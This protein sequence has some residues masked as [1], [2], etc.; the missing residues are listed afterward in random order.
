VS[1]NSVVLLEFKAK[2]FTEP[3]RSGDDEEGFF[4]RLDEIYFK[5]AQQL[6]ST[7]DLIKSNRLASIGLPYHGNLKLYPVVITLQPF[8]VTPPLHR[9][10]MHNINSAK[11]LQQSGVFPFQL[12]DIMELEIIETLITNKQEELHT[13]LER[14]VSTPMTREHGFFNYY[15]S[16]RRIN[17]Q[18][19]A[20]P[21][22][23]SRYLQLAERAKGYFQSMLS[24]E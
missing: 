12:I 10:M 19:I 6:S 17:F 3:M 21:Y 14:K 2:L 8:V 1:G 15:V 5:A 16:Q 13:L 11:L 9:Y 22:L 7:V 4:T 20:N 18:D 23:S 24:A